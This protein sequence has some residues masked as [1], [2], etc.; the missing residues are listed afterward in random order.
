LKEKKTKNFR[1]V[2]SGAK[3]RGER[4]P[5]LER[6]EDKRTFGMWRARL[7]GAA[8]ALLF[9]KEKEAKELSGCRER[10]RNDL[11]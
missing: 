3:R 7:N 9:L 11:V 1:G 10:G 2:K 6:K 4:S 8:N 5:F